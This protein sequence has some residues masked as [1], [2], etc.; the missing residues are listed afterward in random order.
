MSLCT[1][2]GRLYCDHTPEQRGQTS[3]EMMRRM[4]PEEK[5]AWEKEPDDSPKKIEVAR[6]HAHDP[7]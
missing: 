3:A 6:R 4:S 7:V 5:Q 1:V 2:C